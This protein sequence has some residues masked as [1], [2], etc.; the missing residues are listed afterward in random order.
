MSRQIT[1]RFRYETAMDNHEPTREFA[2]GYIGIWDDPEDSIETPT[3]VLEN[4][5]PWME[6]SILPE[7]NIGFILDDGK[8]TMAMYVA[9]YNPDHGTIFLHP[10]PTN[11]DHRTRPDN[12]REID[13]SS[14]MLGPRK[15]YHLKISDHS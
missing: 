12:G 10:L 8:Q 13:Y 2:S 9:G 4:P 15:T 14:W 5:N 3:Y 11:P 6:D 1:K 7:N